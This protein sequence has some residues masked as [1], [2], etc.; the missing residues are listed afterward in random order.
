MKTFLLLLHEDMEHTSNLSPKEMGDLVQAH[1]EWAHTLAE[2][3]HLIS[4]DGLS[5]NGVTIRGKDSVIKD[6]PYMESKEI[7]GGYYLLQA[8]DL[9][10]I[11]E[12][13]RDCPCHLWGGTTEIRPIMETDDYGA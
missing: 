1:T 3:G 11:I 10:T 12:I 8:E 2:A 9:E 5:E 7:I 4:G 6:G 13:A